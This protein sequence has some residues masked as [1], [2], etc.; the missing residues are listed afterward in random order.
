[1]TRCRVRAVSAYFG[2]RRRVGKT[3][4]LTEWCRH[5]DGVY[6]VADRSA[7]ALQRRYLASALALRLPGFDEVEYP[8]WRALLRRLDRDAHNLGWRGSSDRGT[9]CRT[10]L[11]PSRRSSPCCRTGWTRR[12]G[13]S[14]LSCAVSSM[15]MMHSAVLDSGAPLYGRASEAFPVHPLK[16]GFLAEVFPARQRSRTGVGVCGVWA[17]C[18]RYWELAESFGAASECGSGRVGARS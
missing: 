5:N 9:N 7:P 2:G 1:M 8:D 16:P 4:L 3:R 15:R 13:K 10:W 6:A 14:A 11:P 18:H 12:R 17:E